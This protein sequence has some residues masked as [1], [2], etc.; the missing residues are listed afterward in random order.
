MKYLA[1]ILLLM[2]VVFFACGE[3]N[4]DITPVVVRLTSGE[5]RQ[6]STAGTKLK[7]E[8]AAQ[9]LNSR[10][11]N[12]TI[13]SFDPEYGDRSYVDSTIDKAKFD[14]TFLFTVPEFSKDSVQVNLK[15]R[16]EDAEENSYELNCWVT[17][18]GGAQILSQMSGIVIYSGS[19]E[20]RNAFSLKDPSQP[21]VK[22]LA[23]SADIDIFDYPNELAPDALSKEWRTNTD[24]RFAKANSFNYAVATATGI[25]A[26]YSSAVRQK[27][28]TGLS[29]NDI[30]LVG[31]GDNACGVIQITDVVDNSGTDNDFYRFN[32]KS[33][34]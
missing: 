13:K 31:R 10:L 21:F 12:F 20:Q 33:I 34:K 32:I 6:Q 1:F 3:D 5:M 25:K 19:S 22:E 7:F 24:V 4:G 14:Y 27:T 30:I 11:K 2:P 16:A 8:I 9:S 26:N 18:T 29:V 17:V 15:M 23:D 28:V